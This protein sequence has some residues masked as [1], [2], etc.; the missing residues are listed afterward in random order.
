MQRAS[1]WIGVEM[2]VV[3][4]AFVGFD[5][6]IGK[7]S[8]QRSCASDGVEGSVPISPAAEGTDTYAGGI[9][10]GNSQHNNHK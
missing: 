8:A 2:S 3:D 4:D 5:T 10:N 9:T 6:G 7:L 1:R